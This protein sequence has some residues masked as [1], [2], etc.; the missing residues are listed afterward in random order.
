MDLSFLRGIR[1]WWRLG[2]PLGLP[3]PWRQ[4]RRD[5]ELQRWTMKALGADMVLRYYDQGLAGP[6]APL[7]EA[8]VPAGLGSRSCRQEDIEAPWLRHW[9]RVLGHPPFYHRKLWED[10]FIL[11]VLWEA[12]ML[13]P[14]RRALCFAVG[15]EPLPATLAAFGV[16]VLAT[17]IGSADTRAR[18][19]IATGQHGTGTE[20]LYRPHLLAREA[21][22]QRVS[23]RSVDMAAI[24]GD[25]RQGGFDMVWSACAMEHLG[26][27][28]AGG[29]F[30]AQAMA[31]LKPGGIAVHTTEY[32]LD[33]EGPTIEAGRTVL[34]QRRHIA[35]LGARLAAAGH[36][37]RPLDD[38]HGTGL[39]DRFIDLPPY[40]PE[41][42]PVGFLAPPHLR[43]SVGGF[44]ATSAGLVIE[45]GG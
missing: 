23:F 37:L 10:C 11:Q 38:A 18:G 39:M 16:A 19:W 35:A 33:P 4:A 24:P 7:P 28:A 9:C 42:S 44:V 5:A 6:Q 1:R 30:V 21:F 26:T 32:N 25:L 8:P 2:A 31:C 29:R 12:G 27:I 3:Q 36:R 22:D 45:A 20:A 41:R 40:Q 15:E 17:D 43:L 34:F 13:R 14:G